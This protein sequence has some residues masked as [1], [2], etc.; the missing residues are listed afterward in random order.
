[1]SPSLASNWTCQLAETNSCHFQT[2]VKHDFWR[3]CES[4]AF[5]SING[6]K[7]TSSTADSIIQYIRGP[8]GT[9]GRE[10]MDQLDLPFALDIRAPSSVISRIYMKELFSSQVNCLKFTI[11]LLGLQPNFTPG[12]S[13]F[14]NFLFV[15]CFALFILF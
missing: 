8:P 1:M 13:Y 2:E 14:L 15:C 10:R 12:F 5:E 11:Y 7:S 6:A 4:S 3:V 9:K